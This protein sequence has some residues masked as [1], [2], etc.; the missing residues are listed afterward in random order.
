[1]FHY[2]NDNGNVKCRYFPHMSLK[3][4]NILDFFIPT[5]IYGASVS[6]YMKCPS[7]KKRYKPSLLQDFKIF[8]LSCQEGLGAELSKGSDLVSA[9]LEEDWTGW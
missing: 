8:I 1:M 9:T 6:H 5:N 2:E 4:K 3:D 7:A